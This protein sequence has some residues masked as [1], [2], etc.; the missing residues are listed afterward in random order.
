MEKENETMNEVAEKQ[1]VI[2]RI[3]NAPQEMVWKAWTDPEQCMRWW[4][5]KDYTC[6]FCEIDL[7]V[8]GKYLTCMRSPEGKDYWSTGNFI[9]IVP[10]SKL[11]YTDSFAD[12][13]GNKV[14]AEYYG[15]SGF[16]MDLR[17]T[18]TLEE[19]NG[20]TKMTLVHEGIPAGEMQELT[21]GGWNESFDKMAE[22]FENEAQELVITREINAPKQLVWDAFTKA[23]HLANWWG[24]KGSK[25]S[26]QKLDVKPGGVFHYKL[27]GGGNEMWG[28]FKYKEIDAPNSITFISA[29][30]DSDGNIT[31]APFFDGKWPMEILNTWT[32]TE[33]NGKTKITLR[34]KPYNANEIENKAFVDNT[35]SMNQGFGGTFD[36]LEEY[37]KTL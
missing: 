33:E 1:L 25:I 21:S 14:S 28:I 9:E 2:T 18:I 37:L 5:P 31:R 29:F 24:P 34:G 16:P 12:E 15:M 7:K 6:P 11:V 26:V 27:E 8:G 13:N 19:Q 4:G 3:F 30:S 17:V 22:I 36:Q 35:A 32:F 23:E 20:K 10:T